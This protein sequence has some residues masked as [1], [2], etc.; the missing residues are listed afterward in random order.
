[1]RTAADPPPR[2]VA[3]S[4]D[5][6][7]SDRVW[8]VP[9]VLSMARLALLPFFCWLVLDH[10][11]VPGFAVLALSGATDYLDGKIARATG[12]ITRLGQLLDPLADRLYMACTLVVLAVVD[13]VP[14]WLV[15]VLF[16]RELTVA[17]L[18]IPLQRH[19]LPIPPVHF[20][21]KAATFNLMCGLP[22]LL[23]GALDTGVG[24]LARVVGWAFVWWGTG[25]Y[26]VAGAMYAVQVRGMVRAS[27]PAEPVAP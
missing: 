1:M 26:W 21:G 5:H 3:V 20:I 2:V 23:L 13:L 19:H 4:V 18:G 12:Q 22:L 7:L 15:L 11:W 24:T 17:L 14:W 27:E 9:N 6:R 16:A 10:D 8:T 25:L